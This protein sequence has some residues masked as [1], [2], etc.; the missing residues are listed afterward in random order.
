MCFI[1]DTV[2]FAESVEGMHAALINFSEYC[3]VGKFEV[4]VNKTNK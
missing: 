1:D 3:Q 4:D 2:I